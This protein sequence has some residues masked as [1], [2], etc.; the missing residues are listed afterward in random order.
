MLKQALLKTVGKL[1]YIVYTPF[2]K[3][4]ASII[5]RS[6]ERLVVGSNLS[7]SINKYI[8]VVSSI[9]LVA[10]VAGGLTSSHLLWALTKDVPLSFIAGL[11][12]SIAVFLASIA[13]SIWIPAAKYSSRGGLLE[14]KMP[15]LLSHLSLL[16]ASRVELSRAF[17][18]LED[19]LKEPGAFSVELSL[20][21]SLTST[22][23]PLSKALVTVAQ[24][25]PSPTMRELLLGL[26]SIAES[27]GDPMPL[28]NSV[29]ETYAGRYNMRVERAVSDLAIIL[30]FY[31]AL[32]I[33]L[34]I[35]LSSLALLFIIQPVYGF[36]FELLLFMSTFVLAPVMLL[37]TLIIA[38]A[39]VSKLRL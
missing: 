9:S 18:E 28:L 24:V 33:L 39:I 23:V 3:L 17:M 25:T 1:T 35:A 29:M 27:G 32:S 22:G 37:S 34:P 16:L 5:P 31:V 2:Y 11:A 4:C 14:A 38:D 12:A 21:N 36:P 13:F 19:L 20:I 8:G 26:T 15:I 30:E 10:T 7:S 6:V